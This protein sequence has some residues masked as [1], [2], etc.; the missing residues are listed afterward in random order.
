MSDEREISS[1][2]SSAAETNTKAIPPPW[3]IHKNIPKI[4]K[5]WT[6]KNGT[7]DKNVNDDAQ[8][9]TSEKW[10]ECVCVSKTR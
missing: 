2:L 8:S 7:K 3:K 5:G 1:I 9:F 10:Q 4:D 6:Q